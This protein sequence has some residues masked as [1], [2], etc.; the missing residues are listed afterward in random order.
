MRRTEDREGSVDVADRLAPHEPRE[1][2]PLPTELLPDGWH[3]T[4][5]GVVGVNEAQGGPRFRVTVGVEYLGGGFGDE[6]D[7]A[8]V[9]A[10][11]SAN[12]VGPLRG[13]GV[14][15]L[16]EAVTEAHDAWRPRIDER[17]RRLNPP[18]PAPTYDHPPSWEGTRVSGNPRDGFQVVES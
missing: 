5:V 18:A 1:P 17:V 13:R 2:E 4:K 7:D 10:I 14:S 15:L 16:G 3:S 9:I 11:S 8:A 6:Y 12:V